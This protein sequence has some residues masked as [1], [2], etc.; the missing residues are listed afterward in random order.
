MYTATKAGQ[1]IKTTFLSEN[2]HFSIKISELNHTSGH[3]T[4]NK[5]TLQTLQL[6][7]ENRHTHIFEYNIVPKCL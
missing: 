4:E 7:S 5:I 2:S 6:P 1:H 3:V